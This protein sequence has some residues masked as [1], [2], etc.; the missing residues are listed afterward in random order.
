[1]KNDIV[2]PHI[3]ISKFHAYFKKDPASGRMSIWDAESKLGVEIG[4][5]ALPK[6]TPYALESGTKILLAGMINA[7]FLSPADFYIT[8]GSAGG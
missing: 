2:I 3:S 6:E 5:R 4:G 7:T 8:S 1:M